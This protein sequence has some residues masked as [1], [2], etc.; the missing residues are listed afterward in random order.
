MPMSPLCSAVGSGTRSQAEKKP[1][2]HKGN[3]H[4]YIMWYLI[5]LSLLHSL[6]CYQKWRC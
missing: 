5:K 1:R 2:N 3:L 6:V 4:Q